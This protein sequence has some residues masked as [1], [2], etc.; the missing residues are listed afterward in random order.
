M[1]WLRVGSERQYAKARETIDSSF[2]KFISQKREDLFI[3]GIESF[4]LLSSYMKSSSTTEDM[5]D[6]FLKDTMRTFSVAGRDTIASGLTWFFWLVNR[7]PSVEMKILEE[8]NELAFS[9]SSVAEYYS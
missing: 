7:N 2:Q 9:I 4:D 3:K 1:R 5:S 6:K 8:L